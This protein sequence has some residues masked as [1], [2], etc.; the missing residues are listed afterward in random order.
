M[1]NMSEGEIKRA[2]GLELLGMMDG[3]ISTTIITCDNHTRKTAQQTIQ[4]T[5]AKYTILDTSFS[6][7]LSP[8]LI[9]DNILTA[10]E[11]TPFRKDSF[12]ELITDMFNMLAPFDRSILGQLSNMTKTSLERIIRLFPE[13]KK[14]DIYKLAQWTVESRL[15]LG[16]V[17]GAKAAYESFSK[18]EKKEV[19]ARVSHQI[20]VRGLIGDVDCVVVLPTTG[21]MYIRNAD[22]FTKSYDKFPSS[23]DEFGSVGCALFGE[24]QLV[25]FMTSQKMRQL[26]RQLLKA[27]LFPNADSSTEAILGLLWLMQQMLLTGGRNEGFPILRMMAKAAWQMTIPSLTDKESV[28]IIWDILLRGEMPTKREGSLMELFSKVG[29]IP[30]LPP[31]GWALN[32]ALLDDEVFQAQKPHFEMALME[33]DIPSRTADDFVTW[34]ETTFRPYAEGTIPFVDARVRSCQ[35]TY[36]PL[37]GNVKRALPHGDCSTKECLTLTGHSRLSDLEMFGPNYCPSCRGQNATWVD[38]FIP[39]P[40]AVLKQAFVDKK[41]FF[42][43]MD[44]IQLPCMA[45]PGNTG[46]WNWASLCVGEPP[47]V[48]PMPRAGGGGAAVAPSPVSSP[49][50]AP[51]VAVAPSPV[52][53]S[54]SSS[55]NKKKVISVNGS[56]SAEKERAIEILER[57]LGTTCSV[58]TLSLRKK[59][60][61]GLTAKAFNGYAQQTVG[62]R[63]KQAGYLGQIFV[64]II[65]LDDDKQP[66]DSL[67]GIRWSDYTLLNFTSNF[68]AD[69]ASVAAFIQAS[70]IA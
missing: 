40:T 28:H 67:Y 7:N 32:M 13:Q 14:E 66:D 39:D 61:E 24:H 45:R 54:A 52:S 42:I 31:V 46:Q 36:E 6:K 38:A 12:F 17:A 44:G 41:P 16:L 5:S 48:A 26:V 11:T 47:A 1:Q 2:P 53:S 30:F 57:Q 55:S 69:E 51:G 43:K 19:Y 63:K 35:V 65:D 33:L 9:V 59:R 49:G 25:D 50:C 68:W 29:I 15:G 4:G 22:A 23:M 60:A 10:L 18:V 8:S 56:T 64:V 21:I 34:F 20:T 62:Q 27:V 70:A 37:I 58:L 3:C